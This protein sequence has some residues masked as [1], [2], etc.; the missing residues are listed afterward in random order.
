MRTAKQRLN[1]DDGSE[2]G[3]GRLRQ[4]PVA[5]RR[6]ADW[7]RTPGSSAADWV[8]ALPP[9]LSTTGG[10]SVTP[11]S[12]QPGSSDGP[13]PPRQST[14]TLRTHWPSSSCTLPS[15]RTS[16]LTPWRGTFPAWRPTSPAPSAAQSGA[17]T[18]NACG[19]SAARSPMS[20]AWTA[21]ARASSSHCPRTPAFSHGMLYTATSRLQH[22]HG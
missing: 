18:V 6:L 13:R 2:W 3:T 20:A 21:R 11:D 12:G 5:L 22:A 19:S 4:V 8:R 7:T 14:T 1:L 9:P 10:A 15:R 17:S 16:R